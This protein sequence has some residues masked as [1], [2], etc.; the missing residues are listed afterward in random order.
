MRSTRWATLAALV[1]LALTAGRSV[2]A[3]LVVGAGGGVFVPWKGEVGYSVSA[4]AMGSILGD[5]L[6]LGGEFEFRRFDT[7]I[8]GSAW[9]D[10][11][12][13]AEPNYSDTTY[14]N[15]NLRFL[16]SYHPIPESVF[17][18]YVGIGIGIAINVVD[19]QARLF[20]DEVSGGFGML[21]LVGAELPFPGLEHLFFFTE[22][23]AGFVLDI[24]D[25]NV[26]DTVEADEIGG[27]TGMGGLRLRF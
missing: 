5:H 22:A 3:G 26:R 10:D 17:S 8:T 19:D 16:V 2:H 1:A 23:R 6:R 12:F 7:E 27:F 20:R 21:T 25:D 9:F 24:W 14:E 18:P 4:H 11:F 15:Y 13:T